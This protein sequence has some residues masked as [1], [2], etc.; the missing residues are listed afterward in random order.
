MGLA[1]QHYEHLGWT[2]VDVSARES[3]DLRATLD[4]REL[5]IEVKGTTSTGQSVVLTYNEVEHHRAEKAESSLVVVSGIELL[6]SA[7]NPTATGGTISVTEP[8]LIDEQR[9]KPISYTYETGNS[10]QPD[11]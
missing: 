8:W 9:L 11:L 7:D 1:A 3:F 4:E 2:V 10:L 5:H 6:G